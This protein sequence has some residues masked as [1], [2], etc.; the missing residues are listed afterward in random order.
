[1]QLAWGQNMFCEEQQRRTLHS[2][3]TQNLFYTAR[4]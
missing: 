2:A 1:M 4:H 3:G